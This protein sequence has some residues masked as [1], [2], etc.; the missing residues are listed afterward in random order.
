MQVKKLS[1]FLILLSYIFV[2]SGC[3][4]K[5]SQISDSPTGQATEPSGQATQN[6]DSATQA[7]QSMQIPLNWQ[8]TIIYIDLLEE[9]PI[10]PKMTRLTYDSYR[11]LIDAEAQRHDDCDE[12]ECKILSRLKTVDYSEEFFSENT[13][14][15]FSFIYYPDPF[16]VS[17][18][19]R[20][21]NI[22]TCTVDVYTEPPD[23]GMAAYEVTMSVFIVVDTILPQETEFRVTKNYI[24]VEVEEHTELSNDFFVKYMQ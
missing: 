7:T 9:F 16:A 1:V 11:E 22:V 2:L 15:L 8:S 4:S 17:N 21:G 23:R 12:N 3:R 6:S 18:V 14:L 20:E 24:P 10:K 13:V 19:T 5:P